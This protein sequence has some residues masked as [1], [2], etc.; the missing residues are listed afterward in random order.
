MYI[1]FIVFK[2]FLSLS[3]DLKDVLLNGQDHDLT[4]SVKD[5]KF[6]AHR[7]ILR[8]RSKVFHSV[9]N[10][11]TLEKNSGLIDVPDC[12]PQA[13]EQL[14]F[15]VYTGKVEALDENN[16]FSLY[17]AAEKYKMERLK[18]DCSNFIKDSFTVTNV[19][20]VLAL[21]LKH[22]DACLLQYAMKYFFDNIDD[23]L[24][25][26]E[27]QLFVGENSSFANELI[28]L[29]LKLL[30]DPSLINRLLIFPSRQK[31][32]IFKTFF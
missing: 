18:E 2:G 14:L 27:W 25:T 15:Y 29:S 12:E 10:Y 9:L 31:F 28:I 4:F 8:A 1:I 16:M 5:R 13:F 24:P 17:Y 19:S 21:A 30:R 32:R 6:R 7:D 23:I 11:D 3:Q 26:V 22:S 20:N